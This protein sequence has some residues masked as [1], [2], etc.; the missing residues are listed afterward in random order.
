MCPDP[1][2]ER[3]A[4]VSS[5]APAS[6][7]PCLFA[8]QRRLFRGLRRDSGEAVDARQRLLVDVQRV[9]AGRQVAVAVVDERRL[10]RRQISVA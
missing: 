4:R 10:D 8:G 1:F 9:V 5:W 7:R 2:F 6:T 3:I